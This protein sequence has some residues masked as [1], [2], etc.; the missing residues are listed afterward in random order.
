MFNVQYVLNLFKRLYTC[1]FHLKDGFFLRP[2]TR[3]VPIVMYLLLFL[4]VH[5][6][7]DEVLVGMTDGFYINA[8]RLIIYSHRD[9][10]FA[11][12]DRE[13]RSA[14]DIRFP[15]FVILPLPL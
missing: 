9:T 1:S 4:F 14:L 15:V 5:R 10:L 11:M 12:T 2:E 3:E 6:T 8:Y 7:S 13:I